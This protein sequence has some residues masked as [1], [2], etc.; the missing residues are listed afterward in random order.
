M[1]STTPILFKTCK[2][3]K[4]I[5]NIAYFS[6]GGKYKGKQKHKAHCKE[7]YKKIYKTKERN[8]N[9]HLSYK[10][11]LSLKEYENMLKKQGG[12]C[13]ICGI[14]PN[15]KP[16]SVDHCHKTG[17]VRGL[18]CQKH[19]IAIGLFDEDLLLFDRAKQYL[20]LAINN[21]NLADHLK[22]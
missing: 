20:K 18:L 6:K 13:A 7:C 9:S 21:Q 15:K 10:Y 4:K 3:C 2:S 14:K 11:G 12:G 19:N 22:P 16:L 5:L 17:K 8:R 1:E